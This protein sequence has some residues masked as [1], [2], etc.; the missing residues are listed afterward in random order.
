MSLSAFVPFGR[1]GRSQ[2]ILLPS[3]SP[4]SRSACLYLHCLMD[5][6]GEKTRDGLGEKG[7]L[8]ETI[9]KTISPT[10]NIGKLFQ[11]YHWKAYTIVVRGVHSQKILLWFCSRECWSKEISVLRIL[12]ENSDVKSFD[13]KTHRWS[14][15]YHKAFQFIKSANCELLNLS[16]PKPWT[17]PN[18]WLTELDP[19]EEGS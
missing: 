14:W 2:S 7:K 4:W 5:S 6:V 15:G 1:F 13:R 12:L 18:W 3:P 19:S 8:E 10:I 16:W 11:G 17:L 9:E